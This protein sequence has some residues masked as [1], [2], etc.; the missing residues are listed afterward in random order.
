MSSTRNYSNANLTTE[1]IQQ[2]LNIY[3]GVG[4]ADWFISN[5]VSSA[6]T[7]DDKDEI[8][9]N[10]P[11]A[12]Y[13]QWIVDRVAY[14]MPMLEVVYSP[15]DEEGPEEPKPTGNEEADAQ[16]AE[17]YKVAKAE[18]EAK[19]DKKREAIEAKIREMQE[20][21]VWEGDK[22]FW[23][24]VPL[25]RIFLLLCG[26]TFAK[27]PWDEE[28]DGVA[29]ERMSP[30]YSMIMLSGK[31]KKQISGYRFEYPAGSI[32]Y[33][34]DPVGENTI[35]EEITATSWKVTDSSSGGKKLTPRGDKM[36]PE[37]MAAL[38]DIPVSHMAF[39]EREDHPRGLPFANSV[40]DKILHIYAIQLTRRLG[41]KYNGAPIIVRLNAAGR[42]PTFR[43]GETHDVHDKSPLHKADVKAVGGG[44][45]LASTEVEY[46][47]AIKELED[48]AF[49]PHEG[50]DQTS[51]LSAPSG[52]A[53]EQ[54][55]KSQVAFREAFTRIE[56][57][58]YGDLFY[59][60]LRLEGVDV[61]RSEITCQYDNVK[62]PTARETLDRANVLFEQ[63]FIRQGLTEMGFEEDQID[64]MLIEREEESQRAAADFMLKN[65]Q[66]DDEGNPIPPKD[67]PEDEPK[68]PIPPKA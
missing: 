35:I 51:T 56:G 42:A 47:D 40:M 9:R 37:A 18:H 45:S 43:H 14:S 38:K 53:S 10:F 16:A 8:K 12:N 34:P 1:A 44:L 59:K 17:E 50:R 65:P 52:Q 22:D 41:N 31:R 25:W 24:S 6:L 21:H 33:S 4:I 28:L 66:L 3:N 61:S 2:I 27:L 11:R 67:K 15:K 57:S 13:L 30:Q 19:G 7:T 39:K 23:A 20:R 60:C 46:Q 62:Q 63:K 5:V 55:S 29:P 54:L 64:A 68:P 49:L 58:F 36:K 32:T 48:I 26:D